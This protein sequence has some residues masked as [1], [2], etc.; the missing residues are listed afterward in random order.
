MKRKCLAAA[1]SAVLLLAACG[2]GE[3]AVSLNT[4]PASS[5]QGE[6][7]VSS[8]EEESAS[9]AGE[10]SAASSQPPA[11]PGA[12]EETDARILA[13]ARQL[14]DAIVATHA[15]TEEGMT[16]WTDSAYEG[17]NFLLWLGFAVAGAQE[18]SLYSHFFSYDEEYYLHIDADAAGRIPRQALGLGEDWAFDVS[19]MPAVEYDPEARE[20]VTGGGFGIGS[21]WQA[22][23]LAAAWSGEG[24]SRIVVEFTAR[25][26]LPNAIDHVSGQM[27]YSLQ[28]GATVPYLRLESVTVAEAPRDFDQILP[29]LAPT[30]RIRWYDAATGYE[31]ATEDAGM[32]SQVYELLRELII[33]P[34]TPS[35]EFPD[36]AQLSQGAFTVL[37]FYGPGTEEPF[38]TVK[39]QPFSVTQQGGTDGPWA[40]ENERAIAARLVEVQNANPDLW[41]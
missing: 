11:A 22:E 18:E 32:I 37:E 19:G 8:P 38:L 25:P 28:A 14:T 16:P 23:E 6:G 21:G 40:T 30:A 2:Q 3:S 9:S 27:D 5:S 34:D 4:P 10:E 12:E 31:S 29:G 26:G 20:Y 13:A 35:S 15:F 24:D 1:L 33:Y 17:R 41:H 36:A 39:L 7:A